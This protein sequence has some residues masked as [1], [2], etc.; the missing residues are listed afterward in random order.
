[1]ADLFEQNNIK[2]DKTHGDLFEQHGVMTNKN[3]LQNNVQTQDKD[4][5]DWKKKLF[6]NL[7]A[8]SP[9][10]KFLAADKNKPMSWIEFALKMS[11]LGQPMQKID[12]GANTIIADKEKKRKEQINK[13]GVDNSKPLQITEGMK[14]QMQAEGKEN[15]VDRLK[16]NGVANSIPFLSGLADVKDKMAIS[17]IAK[18]INNGTEV[19]PEE[20]ERYN[21][22]MIDQA[23]MAYRGVTIGGKSADVI[24]N[25]PAF[26]GE[27]L[28]TG[29]LGSIG[30]TAVQKTITSGLQEVGEK[31]L[32]KRLLKGTA[33]AIGDT[34]TRLPLG[35]PHFVVEN[36]QDRRMTDGLN[37][38]DKGQWLLKDSQ[39]KPFTT[40][41]KA[42]GDGFIEVFSEMTG[43]GIG[44][45]ASAISRQA[46]KNLPKGAVRELYKFARKITPP[47][48]WA[49][50]LSKTGFHG[51]LEEYGEERLG[52]LLKG[53]TGVDDRNI[54]MLDKLLEA[55][56]PDKEQALVE[57][58]AFSIWGGSSYA[59]LNLADKLL[60]RGVPKEDVENVL[61]S[62]SELEKD[63]MLESFGN[64]EPLKGGVQYNA[65]KE[66]M[67]DAGRN[68]EQ[69]DSDLGVLHKIDEVL[70]NKYDEEGL[71][72]NLI[73]SRNLKAQ[74]VN[75]QIQKKRE[76]DFASQELAGKE[77]QSFSPSELKTDA[78]TFQYKDN[79][80]EQGVTERLQGIEE[81]D[82]VF[83]G[84]VIVYETK[85]GDKYIADGHQRLG[86]A[87]RLNDPN[88]KLNGF[89]F[90]ETDGYTPEQVRVIAAQKNIAEGSGTALDTAKIIK[91]IG[92]DKI[93]KSIPRTSA[94]FQNGVS[95]SR[96]GEEAFD[97]VVN[98]YVTPQ[99]GAVIADIIRTNQEKQSLA[100]DA[101]SNSNLESLQQVALMANEVL[102]AD[103][104]QHEQVNLFGTQ[105]IQESTALEKIKIVDK[106]L[107]LL[108][109]D[110]NIFSGLKRNKGKI[111]KAG[112]VLEDDTNEDIQHK[113]RL[114]IGA[115]EKLASR[116]G[117]ISDKANELALQFK[118]G[119]IKFN[120]AVMQFREFVLSD[121]VLS[122]LY[123]QV[124]TATSYFQSAYHGSPHKF[125]K[126]SLEHIG[127]GEGAQVYGYGLYL[128]G[129]KEIA[130]YY[131]RTLTTSDI[132]Y[133]GEKY[134]A[135]AS[136]EWGL[137][138]R[139][140]G[141]GK[142]NTKEFYAEKAKEFREKAEE[143]VSPDWWLEAAQEFDDTIK[144]ID[145][146][147]TDEIKKDSGQLYEVE[148]PE[149][150]TM[151][152]W[153]DLLDENSKDVNK[154]I[155]DIVEEY[156]LDRDFSP[157]LNPT[158]RDFYKALS[159]ELGSDKEASELLSKEGI[160]GI[161]YLDGSS[162]KK[163]EGTYNYVVFDDKAIDILD[164]Y[165]QGNVQDDSR[166][167]IKFSDN[168]TLIGLL[169]GH[170]AS[171][172]V[173]ELAHLYLHDLQMLSSGNSRA[174]KDIDEIYEWLGFDKSADMSIEQQR[175]FHEKFARGFEA[176]LMNGEAPTKRL[177]TLFDKFK[178]FLKDVY[179]N[180]KDLDV[181]F[182]QDVQRGFDRLFTTDE[183][184][185][186]E[187]LPTYEANYAML[188]SI[189]PTIFEDM[190]KKIKD[191]NQAVSHWWDMVI[192]PN[193]TR[194]AK[195]DINLKN[196]IRKH[197]FDIMN[198]NSKD[199]K[200][201]KPFLQTAEKMRKK[202]E[203]DFAD[204]D[205]AL[206]NRDTY[207]TH[208]ILNKYNLEK[209]FESVKDILEDIYNQ[210]I[211][212][213]LDLGYLD[214]Y[215]PRL[216]DNSKSDSFLDY[217]EKMALKEEID[218]RNQ[219]IDFEE[220]KYSNALKSLRG[221]DPNGLWSKEDKAKFLNTMIRGFGKNN[222]LIS[223]IGQ[224]KFERQIDKLDRELNAFY[225]PFTEALAYYIPNARK[226]IEERKFFG[227]ENR[228]VSKLRGTIKKKRETLKEVKDRRPNQAKFKEVTRLKYEL[229]SV[230]IRHENAIHSYDNAVV[231][232]QNT[233][234]RFKGVKD[235]YAPNLEE[236]K[237]NVDKLSEQRKHLEE[238]IEYVEGENP[239]TV[240]NI[241]M[242]RLTEEIRDANKQIGETIGDDKNVENSIGELVSQLAIKGDIHA[243]DEKIIRDI[244][245]ARFSN[246]KVS[247]AT[248]FIRDVGY[249]GTLN[250]ISNAITQFG[251][252]AL[253]AYKFGMFDTLMGMRRVEGLT[254][255]DMGLNTIAEEF[256]NPE[257]TAKAANNVLKWI[258]LNTIDG[259]GKNTVINASI[260]KARSLAKKN[261]KKLDERLNYL[262]GDEAKQIKQDLIDG[263]VTDG[264]MFIAYNDLADIQPLS[265]DQMTEIYSKGG[266]YRMFYMLKTYSLKALDIVRNEC[267]MKITQGTKEKNAKLIGEGLM[268][269]AKL[270]F[271][272]LMFGVPKDYLVDLILNRD[273]N[274]LDSVVDN[275]I[276]SLFLNRFVM[277]KAEKEGV[278]SATLNFVIPPFFKM[279]DT[280][281]KD[282]SK[283]AKGEEDL[284]DAYGWVYVPFAGKLYYNWFGGSKHKKN[285]L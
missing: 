154:K 269:L 177:Q 175:D 44:I 80:D 37:I 172:V 270:Q 17:S 18:K 102:N 170:D 39:E 138:S 249:I 190:R 241:V 40:F 52:N 221:E 183:E 75:N 267:F 217:F 55:V 264:V 117:E 252:L 35:M 128:A 107:K 146:I 282:I 174:K 1:M 98:G 238:Q 278:G 155:E 104:T 160:T 220:A 42:F 237:A 93:P 126:F 61:H 87:K 209:E 180:L 82:P 277:R 122:D 227:G 197:T 271:F 145:E 38:T 115:I 189:K 245:M 256:Q 280:W 158:G 188:Q 198:I 216:I 129:N 48:R 59:T 19:A 233:Q 195:I 181:E 33:E 178:I 2:V 49:E 285:E 176:Y 29:G 3:A 125:D 211:E 259:F 168:E 152:S 46:L 148:I 150:A 226:N 95:L 70:L 28:A 4:A 258:G 5:L 243:K 130:E 103:T 110:K 73:K 283:I 96:L 235:E 64:Q 118:E 34:A 260:H 173:H 253:S 140:L 171:S 25:I 239:L 276:T 228:E 134:R 13:Y 193:E 51:I 66:Q 85:E 63:E 26:A 7:V 136:D 153:D 224:L 15:F 218:I 251:D 266:V 192:I 10:T 230:V 50:M 11:P 89:L 9:A 261:N 101:V 57:L 274:I 200:A 250:D 151:I 105:M 208:K 84:Q 214:N 207:M 163:G 24:S 246:A 257:G 229:S 83:A 185:E 203:K 81:F 182:S 58:G 201:M 116:K 41:A 135:N 231:A 157:F 187:V 232:T 247:G 131:R 159:D 43:E 78:K 141:N 240:K 8:Q 119:K 74:V 205:L 23:E 149:D 54:P 186:K 67:R 137:Y 165:Y 77:V 199:S 275:L 143:S 120:N 92:E 114:A 121:E 124:S 156:G 30:R 166:A 225:K 127:N 79:S 90:K 162:R 94:L 284:K 142:E 215:F 45:G 244:L 16:Y 279:M 112:N 263:K 72:T 273:F 219:I 242:R 32:G 272:F 111:E 164:T 20:M 76:M 133:K 169:K 144:L 123:G 65:L 139:I 179:S 254:R 281:S 68:D 47:K 97:K 161:K 62:T 22:F 91:E 99:Q 56:C 132:T 206:K 262:F 194:L 109:Q 36:Y 21:Q 255:E 14:A 31:E 69:I 184:Y 204:L 71:A 167:F 212:V 196:I 106:T 268:N 223:R 202:N 213:G 27:F 191:S 248:A 60:S 12:D 210:S 147:N 108:N 234:K 236:L 86:L 222:I 100:V 6:L 265:Q 88:I 53:L 113:S